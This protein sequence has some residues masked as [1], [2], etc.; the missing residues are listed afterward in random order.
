MK[1]YACPECIASVKLTRDQR[2]DARQRGP[3]KK[4]CCLEREPRRDGHS[5]PREGKSTE[6]QWPY[7]EITWRRSMI[8]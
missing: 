7:F 3:P 6:G 1:G 2:R 8:E 5:E 4:V